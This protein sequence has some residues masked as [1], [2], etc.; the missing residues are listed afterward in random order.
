MSQMFNSTD[1]EGIIGQMVSQNPRDVSNE[2]KTHNQNY[3][4]FEEEHGNTLDM[5]RHFVSNEMNQ[6]SHNVNNINPGASASSTGNHERQFTDVLSEALERGDVQSWMAPYLSIFTLG[7]GIGFAAGVSSKKMGG[8]LLKTTIG[9][10]LIIQAL[11][12]KGYV[13][14]NWEAIKDDVNRY[15]AQ[16]QTTSHMQ[17]AIANIGPILAGFGIGFQFS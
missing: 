9:S 3:S 8:Y 13:S 14:I 12:Y 15:M 17:F 1:L 2:E 4:I 5:D 6:I 7:G 11:R 16:Q 10:L